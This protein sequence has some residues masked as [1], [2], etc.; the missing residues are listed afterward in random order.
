MLYPLSYEGGDGENLGQNLGEVGC[1]DGDEVILG[2]IG[3]IRGPL[4]LSNGARAR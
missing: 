3:S 4:E 1:R 2:A